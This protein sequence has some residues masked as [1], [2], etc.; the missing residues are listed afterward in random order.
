[1][2]KKSVLWISQ[3]PGGNQGDTL[4]YLVT[5]AYYRDKLNLNFKAA[6]HK[7]S[8]IDINGIGWWRLPWSIFVN[9]QTPGTRFTFSPFCSLSNL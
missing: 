3:G 5:N 7:L 2:R 1:M 6:A 4:L 9:Q 8:A